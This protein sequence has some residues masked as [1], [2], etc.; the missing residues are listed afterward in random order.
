[1]SRTAWSRASDLFMPR[2][3]RNISAI[4]QPTGKTGLSEDSASWK[5]IEIS[6]PA[7]HAAAPRRHQ[8]S[9]SCP[10]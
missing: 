1:M 10:Q 7:G 8:S 4:C 6:G 3:L 9:R 5:T 2:C